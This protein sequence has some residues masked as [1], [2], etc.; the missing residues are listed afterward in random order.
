MAL[1]GTIELARE[2]EVIEDAPV[3]AHTPK[4]RSL[5]IERLHALVR[6]G[7]KAEFGT[8]GTKEDPDFVVLRHLGRTPD[9]VL[10]EDG[11]LEGLEGRRPRYKRHI[12]PPAIIGGRSDADQIRF[13]KFIETI[14]RATLF[15]RTRPWRVKYVYIPVAL[16]AIWG[17]CLSFTAIVLNS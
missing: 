13:M 7:Y 1:D 5:V 4:T 11:T 8:L 17:L 3:K 10:H 14:P 6:K 15:D 9:L 12:D 16:I 2:L